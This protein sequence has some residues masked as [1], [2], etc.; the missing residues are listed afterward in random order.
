MTFAGGD[1][2][3]RPASRTPSGRLDAAVRALHDPRLPAGETGGCVEREIFPDGSARDIGTVYL[4][5]GACPLACLYCALYRT[6]ADRPASGQEIA[7]QIRSARGRMPAVSGLKLYNA[8]SLF[9]PVSIRQEAESLEAIAAA[10]A[11]LDLVVVEARS[12]NAGRA[13]DFAR[14]ISGRLEVAIGLE[15]ADDEL[16]SLLNKPTTVARFREAARLLGRRDVLLRAFVLVQPPFVSGAAARDLAVRTFELAAA[17]GARVVS[18][19][20]VVSRHAPM[21]RLRRAGFFTEPSLDDF[22][23]VVSACAGRGPVVVAETEWL[24]RLPGCPS[25]REE[26]AL[27]LERLDATGTLRNLACFDHQP[28]EA[29]PVR[30]PSREEL[31]ETLRR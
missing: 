7:R 18:F 6:A 15:V 12:E 28:A 10:L 8:S 22:F 24:D 16:L 9:E 20:P 14:R 2:I 27:A 23:Q 21:E 29:P 11:G 1:A 25:C 31:A 26:K 4:R 5:N 30:R 17:E 13:P 19:L 3:G